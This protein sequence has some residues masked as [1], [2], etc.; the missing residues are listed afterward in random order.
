MDNELVTIKYNKR[1]IKDVAKRMHD[2]YGL[3]FVNKLVPKSAIKKLARELEGYPQLEEDKLFALE[4]AAR[5]KYEI[6]NN[7]DYHSKETCDNPLFFEYKNNEFASKK[8]ISDLYNSKTEEVYPIEITRSIERAYFDSKKYFN[9]KGSKK[10][11]LNT[12]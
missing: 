2:R 5:I 4:Y 8:A 12:K 11:T 10:L 3:I 1:D 9:K 6:L 7:I